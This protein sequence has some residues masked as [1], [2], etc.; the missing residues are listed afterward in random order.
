VSVPITVTGA[1]WLS[2][3]GTL[4]I[5]NVA[6]DTVPA[7]PF[8]VTVIVL[9]SVVPMIVGKLPKQAPSAGE[10]SA[11]V[12][13]SSRSRVFRTEPGVDAMRK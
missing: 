3:R 2:T 9:S 7:I 13:G 6:P 11:S 8:A 4:E 10:V 12:G 5:E 1:F